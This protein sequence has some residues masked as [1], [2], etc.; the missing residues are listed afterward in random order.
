MR[1]AVAASG[2]DLSS[3]LADRFARADYFIVYDTDS[4]EYEV[5]ENQVAMSQAHGAGPRVVQMIA[6]LGVDAVILPGIGSNAFDALSAAGVKAYI[7]KPVSVE[8]NIKMLLNGELEEVK[9]PTRG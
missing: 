2:N 5:V 8:E 1:V 9:S 4:G 3:K 6:S 7:G